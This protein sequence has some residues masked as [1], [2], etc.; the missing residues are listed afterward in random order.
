MKK[1]FADQGYFLRREA[2]TDINA[3]GK[4]VAGVAYSSDN[5]IDVRYALDEATNTLTYTGV[6]TGIGVKNYDVDFVVRGY[7]IVETA[8]GKRITVYD[9]QVTLS[10]YDA[11]V[12]IVAENANA[13]D[14]AIA[15]TVIDTYDAYAAQ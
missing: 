5:G 9:D 7:A 3:G 12:Q 15:Q 13:S 14:V 10:V 4:A 1:T 6:L 8:D 11:A 2:A